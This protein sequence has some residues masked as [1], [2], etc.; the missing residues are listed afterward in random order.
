MAEKRL[1][2]IWHVLDI[3][4]AL[5]PTG[6]SAYKL[7]PLL[8][9]TASRNSRLSVVESSS[10]GGGAGGAG[11][12]GGGGRGGRAAS[13]AAAAR[14]HDRFSATDRI[15]ELQ[16]LF[17][18]FDVD[19]NGAIDCD[20]IAALLR[21]LG[22]RPDSRRISDVV[23]QVDSNSNGQL[24]FAEFCEFLKRA[25]QGDV[26]NH[27][28]EA[29]LDAYSAAE[30]GYISRE[31]LSH[32]THTLATALGQQICDADV[33]DILALSAP[34]GEEDGGGAEVKTTDVAKVMLMPREKRKH[35]A[36]L[37]RRQRSD[38]PCASPRAGP[39]AV[40]VH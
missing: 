27:A 23:Q 9:E 34:D 21:K 29:S 17:Q 35:D 10:G 39:S 31:E 37:I 16:T 36:E 4:N 25:K 38:E 2:S 13:A 33:D 20:E 32:L 26:L 24:E 6:G 22:L 5:E 8:A 7:P 28:V 11:S 12:G 14:R 30:D 18:M 3:I 40:A 15:E 1:T 19:G